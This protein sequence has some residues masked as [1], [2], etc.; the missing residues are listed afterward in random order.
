M[1]SNYDVPI[2]ILHE[3]AAQIGTT[4]ALPT[5]HSTRVSVTLDNTSSA[6]AH[7]LMITI[8][9]Y[10]PSLLLHR[11]EHASTRARAFHYQKPALSP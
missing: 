2:L 6:A 10:P 9:S 5:R 1:S 4:C 7:T 3:R 11:N 8:R